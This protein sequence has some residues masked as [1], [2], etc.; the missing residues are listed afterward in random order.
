MPWDVDIYLAQVGLKELGYAVGELDGIHGPKFTRCKAKLLTEMSKV[1]SSVKHDTPPA[2]DYRSMVKYYGKPGD[3]SA[4]TR[5]NFPYPMRL[6]WDTSVKVTRSR[7]HTRILQPLLAALQELLDTYGIDWIKRH[8]L[9]L[10][11]GIYNNRNTRG[12]RTKSKH[13]YGAAI[14]LNPSANGNRTPWKAEMIG[15]RGYG[16]MPLEAIIIFERHGFKSAARA[17]GRDAM[18]FEYST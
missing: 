3:E 6:A 15:K 9:D 13:A 4:L 5:I 11:G 17:W 14:D 8:G 18:H 7:C 10:F 2:S 12:G 1:R 16:N